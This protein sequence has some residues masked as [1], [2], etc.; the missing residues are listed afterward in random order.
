VGD[1][2]GSRARISAICFGRRPAGDFRSSLMDNHLPQGLIS[3]QGGSRF[4]LK[5]EY[6]G[7]CGRVGGG[8]PSGMGVQTPQRPRPPAT[9]DIR[10]TRSD[11]KLRSFLRTFRFQTRSHYYNDFILIPAS[12]DCISRAKAMLSPLADFNF[13]ADR[14]PHEQRCH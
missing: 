2:A 10:Q 9:F 7:S 11:Q 14:S 13:S 5:N 1:F 3:A 12:E 6:L 4:F 8:A